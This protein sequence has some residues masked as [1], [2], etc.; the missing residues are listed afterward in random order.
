MDWLHPR[1]R[2]SEWKQ[3]WTGQTLASFSLPP[4]PLLAMFAIVILLLSISQGTSYK[5]QLDR[6]SIIFQLLLF[7]APVFLIFL[8]RSSF[9]TWRFNFWA[10]QPGR[11]SFRLPGGFPWGVA[12]SVVALLVLLSYQSSFQS[13]WF[14]PFRRSD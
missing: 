5:E 12:I 3:G 11:D 4:A 10:P 7:L 9:T 1:R 14:L 13:K 8:M 6:A 2:G